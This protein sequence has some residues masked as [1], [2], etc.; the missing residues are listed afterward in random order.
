MSNANL[1]DSI[2]GYFSPRAGLKRASFR[3]AMAQY[4]AA[5]P[6]R[7]RKF[8]RAAGEPNNIVQRNAAAIRDQ[9]RDLERN[10]DLARGAMRTLVNNVIG[11][12]GIGIEPQPRKK[13]GSIHNEYSRELLRA[14]RDFCKRP[15]VTHQFSWS[16]CQ[17][18]MARTWLRDGESFAQ[19]LSG[20]VPLLDHGTRVP[21]S[22]ELIEPDLLP[23]GYDDES[24]R[25]SQSIERN[26][27]GKPVA[28]WVL[29]NHP[30][31]ST[32][33]SFKGGET[34]RIPFD[35]M[36][37]VATRDRIG[38]LRGVS[39]FAS[40]IT[41]LEDNKDYEE[42]ERVAAKVAA[43][44]TAFVRKGD[45]AQYGNESP[46]EKDANGKT[47]PRE[48]RFQPGTIIDNLLPGED[49]GLIDSKRP[50][51]NVA[52]FRQ[53]QLRA[54]AAGISVSYSSLSKDY[55]G[56]YSAQRQE[57]V[58]Q[59]VHY[60]VLTDEFVR[61]FVQ[62]VWE[63]FVLAADLSGVVRI[64]NDVVREEADD[65]L[66]VAQQMPWIDPLKE[67][68]GYKMMVRAG[69]ASEYDVIRRRGANPR[70]VLEQITAH[71]RETDANGLVFD[72]NAKS[73]SNAGTAQD[74]LREKLESSALQDVG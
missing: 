12:Q 29:K 14:W 5:T 13:D 46:L 26:T 72:S 6:S 27:W 35:R 11:S 51:P 2:V 59:W 37:H 41:R 64:P 48:I 10:H 43:S 62:P 56:T 24:K 60:A 28:F 58:D 53:G 50:N 69:F 18:I 71:R 40:V 31:A 57:L 36:L 54:V 30:G 52:I 23:L 39:E 22:V 32:I 7:S 17:R 15:E 34:K 63:A 9:V 19:I 1:F 42:S 66:W 70:D 65:A 67:A 33:K 68:M 55:N 74:Y 49:V 16:Q 4:D 8:H 44:L 21:L 47:L 3:A 38:Q 45:S 73:T 20:P 25:I 61:L